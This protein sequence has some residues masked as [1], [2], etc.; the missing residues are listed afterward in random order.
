MRPH[1]QKPAGRPS[2]RRARGRKRLVA[3]VSKQIKRHRI[4]MAL[5]YPRERRILRRSQFSALFLSGAERFVSALAW[6]RIS[7][8]L[9]G[10]RLGVTINTL[11]TPVERDWIN[12]R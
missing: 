1:D 9:N 6:L 5:P 10:P 2:R 4:P 8:D 12:V 11:E 7:N 3:K